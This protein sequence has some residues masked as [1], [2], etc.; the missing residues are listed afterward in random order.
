M[1]NHR[2]GTGIGAFLGCVQTLFV[3]TLVVTSAAAAES[4]HEAFSDSDACAATLEP[5]TVNLDDH[6]V[7]VEA[8]TSEPI[9]SL[10]DAAIDAKSEV[11]IEVK[12]TGI[13]GG[14]IEIEL[15]LAHAEPGAWSVTLLGLNGD[16][17]GEIQ[18]ED[19]LAR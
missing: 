12:D 4:A 18:I 10:V 19:D 9:G 13:S 1:S 8:M 16:C 11:E 15:D 17:V 14:P 6:L 7:R 5:R 2:F 3:L